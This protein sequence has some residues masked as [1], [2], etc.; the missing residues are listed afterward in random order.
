MQEIL[1][2][3]GEGELTVPNGHLLCFFQSFEYEEYASIF[4]LNEHRS[5][6]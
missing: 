2:G 5:D 6:F 1:G 3:G 4:D